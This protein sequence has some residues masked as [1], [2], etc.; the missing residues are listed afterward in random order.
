M[1]VVSLERIKFSCS[2]PFNSSFD[3]TRNPASRHIH[4]FRPLPSSRFKQSF[5]RSTVISWLFEVNG[6]LEIC[7]QSPPFSGRQSSPVLRIHFSAF[8]CSNS[9]RVNNLSDSKQS[10]ARFPSQ[11][12]ILRPPTSR[13]LLRCKRE[14]FHCN[15]F[16]RLTR[17]SSNL[18]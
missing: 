3:S 10:D 17:H 16:L 2:R 14:S 15:K 7:P 8:F 18:F 6:L 9:P 5:R 4:R 12:S 11:I 13:L 1:F